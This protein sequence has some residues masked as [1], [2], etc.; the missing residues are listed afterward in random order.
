VYLGAAPGAG[1]TYATLAAAVRLRKAGIRVVVGVVETHGRAGTEAQLAALEMV[2]R[3]EVVYRGATFGELDLEAVLACRPDA[4]VVDEL[5]HSN[6]PG[7][8][9]DKRWQDVEELLAAGIDVLTN[10]NVQ[11]LDSLNGAAERITGRAQRETVPDAVVS[12]AETVDLVEVDPDTLR[13]RVAERDDASSALEGYFSPGSLAALSDLARQWL[14]THGLLNVDVEEAIGLD[15]DGGGVVVALTGAP[16]G[17]RVVRRAA[18]I[19]TAAGGELV[20]VHVTTPSGLVEA[21]PVWLERQ[22][23]LLAQL[24]GRFTEVAGEHVAETVLGFALAEDAAH[25]VLGATRRSRRYEL[26][27]GSVIGRALR[28]AGPIEVHIVPWK[29]DGARRLQQAP[30]EWGGRPRLSLPGRRR[31]VAW[32]LAVLAPVLLTVALVPFRSSLGVGGALFCVLIAV[33]AVAAIG[34][35]APAMLATVEGVL[36]GDFYFT[37]PFHSFRVD[38]AIDIIALVAFAVVAVVVGILVDVLSR[39]AVR[40]AGAQA[41]AENLA[42]LVAD[43]VASPPESLS[44]LVAALRRTFELDS[45]AVFRRDGDKWVPAATDGSPVPSQPEHASFAATL[46]DGTVLTLTGARVTE[47]DAALL[48]AFMTELR[49]QRERSQLARV[50]ISAPPVAR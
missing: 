45:V 3:R 16:E 11:H 33:V 49:L 8:R 20:G 50:E 21:E 28:D 19:A 39:Q 12:N 14:V 10:L 42:R 44:E 43:S 15:V 24:G 9:H 26:L 32:L 47:A 27:H 2:P 34:G 25:L 6:V 35:V 17:E 22:R 37:V 40:V 4:V 23:R 13:D 31:L 41:E 5:A 38:R 36:L 48:R 46:T 1:K 29:P 18:E 7:S 30:S